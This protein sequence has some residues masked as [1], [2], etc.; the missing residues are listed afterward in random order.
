MN[1]IAKIQT[2]ISLTLKMIKIRNATVSR[3]DKICDIQ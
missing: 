2:N 3:L 1:S